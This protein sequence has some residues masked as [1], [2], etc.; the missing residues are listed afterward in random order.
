MNRIFNFINKLF[1]KIVVFIKF[2]VWGNYHIHPHA[3]IIGKG[4]IIFGENNLIFSHAELNT[5]AS[6]YTAPFKRRHAKGRIEIKS[7]VKIKD[8][9]KII[10]YDGYVIIG[11]NTSINP[12]TIIYGNGGVSIGKNV[13]IAAHCIIVSSNHNFS[14]SDIPMNQQGLSSK[15]IIIEDNVWIGSGVKIL[16][17]VKIGSGSVIAAGAVVTKDVSQFSISAGVPARF[18]KRA[19]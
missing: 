11:E 16:D 5:S 1:Q 19:N 14:R 18:I 6:P 8:Y 17:G 10:T 4:N 3:K 12:Y 9:V 7:N 13:M 2:G 15:G